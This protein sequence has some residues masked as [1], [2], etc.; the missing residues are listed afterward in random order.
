M[1]G[2]RAIV[3]IDVEGFEPNVVAGL[4][5]F[6]RARA[7]AVV[8]EVTP[9]WIGGL[10]GVVDLFNQLSTLGFIAWVVRAGPRLVISRCNPTDVTM[11]TNVYFMKNGFEIESGLVP[12]STQ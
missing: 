12:P 7:Q 6:L 4:T 2:S 5:E 9:E 10:Q 11:Q 1:S 3:K 8:V